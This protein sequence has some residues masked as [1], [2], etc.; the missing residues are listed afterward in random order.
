MLTLPPSQSVAQKGE[1][2]G[3]GLPGHARRP[4]LT[5]GTGGEDCKPASH[6]S[7]AVNGPPEGGRWR[8]RTPTNDQDGSVSCREV[9]AR[10]ARYTQVSSHIRDRQLS[11]GIAWPVYRGQK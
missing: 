5:G 4:L 1:G 11:I 8:A 7:W 9:R 6:A 3:C 10:M 2:P